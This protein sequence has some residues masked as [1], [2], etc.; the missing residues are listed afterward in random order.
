MI[1]EKKKMDYLIED[2]SHTCIFGFCE[3]LRLPGHLPAPT[4]VKR[5]YTDSFGGNGLRFSL[6]LPFSE[7]I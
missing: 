4:N 1:T 5:M 3:M 7:L 6:N 2:P